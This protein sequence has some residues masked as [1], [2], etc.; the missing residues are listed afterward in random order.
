MLFIICSNLTWSEYVTGKIG[1][2]RGPFKGC[3]CQWFTTNQG[4]FWKGP[5]GSAL[6]LLVFGTYLNGKAETTHLFSSLLGNA[7]CA[8]LDKIKIQNDLKIAEMV[9]GRCSQV[10]AQNTVLIGDEICNPNAAQLSQGVSA[11]GFSKLRTSHFKQTKPI[12]TNKKTVWWRTACPE[13]TVYHE[14]LQESGLF[15]LKK[16]WELSF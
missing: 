14:R 8:L 11:G 10:S 4:A 6:N 13:D 1:S 2:G 5:R 9:W 12:K 3:G 7:T 15:R 16:T